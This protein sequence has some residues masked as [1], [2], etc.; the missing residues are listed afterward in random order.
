M[1]FDESYKEY[2]HNP[3][4][5][6]HEVGYIYY[7]VYED[8][9]V[10]VGQTVNL[11][12]RIGSHISGKE[13]LFDTIK[14]KEYPISQLF[15]EELKEIKR[16]TPIYNR[17]GISVADR[18][19]SSFT[20]VIETSLYY[21]TRKGDKILKGSCE[22]KDK[23][24]LF[25]QTDMIGCNT[26]VATRMDLNTGIVTYGIIGRTYKGCFINTYTIVYNDELHDYGVK[27]IFMIDNK[28]EHLIIYPEYKSTN[29][30]GR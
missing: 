14:Y 18:N 17:V 30:H 9:V 24:A 27:G 15:E 13:K 25:I 3:K 29:M 5:V 16:F 28:E 19:K 26:F 4:T 11:E 2:V 1:I 20:D 8:Q 10:Y 6:I 7:L 12:A 21:I 22:L 23:V